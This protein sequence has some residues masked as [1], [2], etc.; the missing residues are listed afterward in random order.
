MIQRHLFCLVCLLVFAFG[1]AQ[2]LSLFQKKWFVQ[3]NDTLPYRILLPVD[4]KASE[5]YP[6]V[7]FLHGAGE[8]GSDNEKQLVHGAKLFLNDTVRR[9]F[10]AIVVFPQCKENSY[11]S[12]V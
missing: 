7:L 4:Y 6:L 11:W 9:D 10:P 8:R 3:N 2:D 12:N 5:K 1:Q